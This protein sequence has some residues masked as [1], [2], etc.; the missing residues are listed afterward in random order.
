M[1]RRKNNENF[2]SQWTFI[3]NAII[4][5]LDMREIALS[6]RQF[7][8]ASNRSIPTFEKLDKILASA[9][10]KEKFP[11]VM[12]RAL[13]RTGTCHTPLLIDACKPAHLGRNSYF[14]FKLSWLHKEGLFEMVRDAWFQGDIVMLTSGKIR[15]DS[16]INFYSDGLVILVGS[17]KTKRKG[18]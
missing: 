13:T 2:N 15:F 18:F 5:N 9:E 17:T 10:W 12:V 14:P 4:E 11:L 16:Y 6:G 8:W 3:F 7:T 1:T